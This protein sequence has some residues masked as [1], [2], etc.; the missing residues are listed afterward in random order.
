MFSAPRLILSL[1]AVE[2]SPL[3]LP[4]SFFGINDL[5]ALPLSPALRLALDL[6]TAEAGRRGTDLRIVARPEIFT[7]GETLA[8]LARETTGA[9]DHLCISDGAAIRVLP[10][11]QTHVF[12]HRLGTSH[13]AADLRDLTR[14]APELVGQI[15]SQINTAIA[16]AAAAGQSW[17]RPPTIILQPPPAHAPPD[18]A[19][20]PL[21]LGARTIEENT[22]RILASPEFA[23]ASISSLTYLAISG[24][25]WARGA[26]AAAAAD[27][28]VRAYLNPNAG[29][30]I[31]LPPAEPAIAPAAALAARL[32]SFLHTLRQTGIRFPRAVP[33]NIALATAPL[34]LAQLETLPS[35]PTMLI[36]AAFDAWHHNHG[37]YERFSHLTLLL[38]RAE[39]AH[40]RRVRTLLRAL[41]GRAPDIHRV[42]PATPA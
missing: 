26:I 32:A 2:I 30:I 14:R 1:P 9:T 4:S 24:A 42:H 25:G 37:F 21:Y 39:F 12:F 35:R 6:V 38:E 11:L 22:A 41:L 7:N 8:W 29:V 16:F 15:G 23:L 3:R 20:L 40:W 34:P 27:V 36:D 17:H 10:G 28:I 33:P 13:G 19:L 5:A 18:A 31:L